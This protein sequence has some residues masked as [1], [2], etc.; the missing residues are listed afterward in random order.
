LVSIIY[1]LDS[2]WIK[3][4]SIATVLSLRK[5]WAGK[6]SGRQKKTKTIRPGVHLEYS[7]PLVTDSNGE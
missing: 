2:D 3:G 1:I 4:L 5:K 6:G 7:K